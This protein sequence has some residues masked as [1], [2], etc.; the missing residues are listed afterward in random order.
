MLFPGIRMLL[1]IKFDEG[2]ESK[3]W[4]SGDQGKVRLGEIWLGLVKQYFIR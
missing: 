1:K 3:F 2:L 4:F